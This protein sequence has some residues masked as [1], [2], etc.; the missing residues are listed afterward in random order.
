MDENKRLKLVEIKYEVQRCCG[1]CVHG[2]FDG[3][4]FGVCFK[5]SYQHLKHTGD[6]RDLS[7]FKYGSCPD[8]KMTGQ[9]KTYMHA[10]TEFLNG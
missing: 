6:N 9:A 2:D 1:M 10:Y 7:V 4:D 8:F 3:N 5:H